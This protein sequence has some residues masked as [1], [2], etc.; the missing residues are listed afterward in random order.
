VIE[1]GVYEFILRV[2][3]TSYLMSCDAAN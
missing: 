2:V 3:R 1:N